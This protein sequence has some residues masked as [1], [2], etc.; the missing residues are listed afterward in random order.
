[1]ALKE[2][3]PVP[4]L[5]M[6]PLPVYDHLSRGVL[7]LFGRVDV[8]DE[9]VLQAQVKALVLGIVREEEKGPEAQCDEGT[10]DEEQDELLGEPQRGSVVRKGGGARRQSWYPSA[11]QGQERRRRHGLGGGKQV[12]W[13]WS[14]GKVLGGQGSLSHLCAQASV[15]QNEARI[16]RRGTTGRRSP[17]SWRERETKTRSSRS[18]V[19]FSSHSPPKPQRPPLHSPLHGSEYRCN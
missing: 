8:G 3:L 6:A 14:L 16:L 11:R 7:P 1:M 4:V 17:S 13:N 12:G 10:E 9:H 15:D 5:V 19:A 18:F 2:L